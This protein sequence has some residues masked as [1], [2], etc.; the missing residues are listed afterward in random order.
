M[1]YSQVM[2]ISS[3]NILGYSVEA[4]VRPAAISYWVGVVSLNF[5]SM[6]DITLLTIN[7]NAISIGVLT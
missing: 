4:P 5:F 2:G 7:K 3:F 6:V 1:H